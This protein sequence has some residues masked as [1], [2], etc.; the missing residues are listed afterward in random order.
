[1]ENTTKTKITVEVTVNAPIEKIW[2]KFNTPAH[3]T[4][5]YAASDDWHAPA[6]ENDFK[7]GGKSNTR[8]EAKD[9]S[10]GFDFEW[11][12]TKIK[13]HEAIDY[14]IVDGRTVSINF[15]NTDNGVKITETFEAEDVNSIELQQGG[16]QAILNNFKKYAEQN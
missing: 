9:G 13:D 15:Q 8:M 7:V 12:Y 4:K 16:W 2:E 10:V 5:W 6:A 11:T 14:T 1:M 3:I